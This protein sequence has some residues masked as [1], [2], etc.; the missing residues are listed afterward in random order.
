MRKGLT[1]NLTQNGKNSGGI[2]GRK[3]AGKDMPLDKIGPESIG[4]LYPLPLRAATDQ[5]AGGSNPSRRA[6]KT[7]DSAK[8]RRFFL[9]FECSKTAAFF[10]LGFIWGLLGFYD[11]QDTA[12]FRPFF[13]LGAS[14]SSMASAAA[15][16]AD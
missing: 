7:A 12:G 15:A 8:N 9:T 5:K 13:G 10:G 4:N 14:R 11:T 3:R 1:H 16:S 6:R 2:S